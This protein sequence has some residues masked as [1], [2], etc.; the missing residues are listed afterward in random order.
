MASRLPVKTFS[1]MRNKC[2]V[3]HVKS[4]TMLDMAFNHALLTP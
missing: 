4:Y 1:T 3:L 2:N